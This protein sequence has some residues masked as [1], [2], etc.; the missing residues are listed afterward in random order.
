VST[1]IHHHQAPLLV[2]TIAFLWRRLRRSCWQLRSRSDVLCL[3]GRS[4][5]TDSSCCRPAS[6][7][8][9]NSYDGEPPSKQTCRDEEKDPFGLDDFFVRVYGR[10]VTIED[11]KG[12]PRRFS[13]PM[14]QHVR[15]SRSG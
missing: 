6:S 10:S 12:V 4:A 8:L 5:T 14:I 15:R 13:H 3:V 1:C 11:Q 9:C 7:S 2:R